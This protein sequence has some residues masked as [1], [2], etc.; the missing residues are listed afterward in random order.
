MSLQDVI[1]NLSKNHMQ[2]K[3]M[4]G[5]MDTINGYGWHTKYF[6]NVLKTVEYCEICKNKTNTDYSE[7]A[8]RGNHRWRFKTIQV[9][10]DTH[11]DIDSIVTQ[12]NTLIV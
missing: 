7:D 4:T 3:I 12:L 5:Y 8:H 10:S 2:V 11:Y 6:V 1:E 9:Y